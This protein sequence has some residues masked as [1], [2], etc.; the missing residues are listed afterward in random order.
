MPANSLDESF[1]RQPSSLH[2]SSSRLNYTY[3]MARSHSLDRKDILH[4]ITHEKV[5][6]APKEM[7][8]RS[9]NSSL[10]GKVQ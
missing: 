2:D 7:T 1:M 10:A 9:F 4:E 3:E 5:D 8:K 6:F